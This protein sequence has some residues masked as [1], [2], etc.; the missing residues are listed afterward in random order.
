MDT[1]KLPLS[2]IL[3]THNEEANIDDCL[4]SCTKFA[5][6]VVVVDDASEDRTVELASKYPEAK[7]FK[8]LLNG[9]FGAQKSFGIAQAQN[10]WIF[11]IDADERVT[12]QLEQAICSRIQ[13]NEKCAYLIQRENHFKN[14]VA[15]HGTMRPDWVLRLM[16]REGASVEGLVHETV[17]SSFPKKRITG[18]RL[19]H[20]P[21]RTWDQFYSKMDQYTRLVALKLAEQ[22]R[23]CGFFSHVVLHPI[24][25]FFKVYFLNLGFLDGK[26]GFIF[27]SNHAAYTLL[28]YV[29]FYQIRKFKGE[30]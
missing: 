18:A 3:L 27:A 15:R 23:P 16:P 7:I 13:S 28:K 26:A 4:K 21:Y 11:L 22:G 5:R 24:W 9:D 29:R 14:M 6:E 17:R 20:F 10:E 12:P 25:A 19:I 30:L 8:R 2:V 1:L